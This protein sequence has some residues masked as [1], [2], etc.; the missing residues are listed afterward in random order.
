MLGG[1]AVGAGAVLAAACGGGTTAMTDEMPKEEKAEMK[2]EEK[3]PVA[4]EVSILYLTYVRPAR[5]EA[6]AALYGAFEEANP[7]I[8]LDL[9]IIDGGGQGVR[10]NIPI[11]FAAGTPVGLFEN[12]WGTWLQFVEGDLIVPLGPLM[13]RDGVNPYETFIA[14]GVDFVSHRGETYGFPAS[15]SVDSYAYNKNLFDEAGL[16]YPPLDPADASWTMERF[17]DTAEKLTKGTEQFGMR[18]GYTGFNTFGIGDGTFFGG[19]AW[20]A[21]NQKATM[22]NQHYVQGINFWIDIV[23]KFHVMPTSEEHSAIVGGRTGHPFYTTGAFGMSVMFVVPPESQEAPFDWGIGALPYTGEP[24]SHS[25]RH[26]THAVFAGNTDHIDQTW[27]V[28]KWLLAGDNGL[29]YLE[30][31]GH[32]VTP[33]LHLFDQAK[34]HWEEKQG[35]NVDGTAYFLEAQHTP[36]SGHGML[37]YS[38][39]YEIRDILQPIYNDVRARKATIEEFL[40]FADTHINENLKVE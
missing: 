11:L 40:P 20:D 18:R 14:E 28:L 37:K 33:M 7:G 39:F 1:F 17:I 5:N 13:A 26:Y 32:V 15:M 36:Q 22:N 35:G 21:E 24:P 19:L 10:Q 34:A 12:T 25:G 9:K 2:A 29:T 16:A 6:E 30:L 8:T 38:N 23:D 4:E 31:T 3:A 27:E